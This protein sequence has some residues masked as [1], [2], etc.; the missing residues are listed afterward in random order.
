MSVSRKFVFSTDDW[1]NAALKI[2][3][4][5][6]FV[7]KNHLL[8]FPGAAVCSARLFF[9]RHL[10]ISFGILGHVTCKGYSQVSLLRRFKSASLN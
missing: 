2:I 4:G 9:E 10:W 5:R 6:P 1:R 3:L 8:D 7:F